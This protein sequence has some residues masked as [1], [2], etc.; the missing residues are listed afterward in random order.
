MEVRSESSFAEDWLYLKLNKQ[1]KKSKRKA[2][3][4]NSPECVSSPSW[5]HFAGM[6]QREDAGGVC[7]LVAGGQDYC[8]LSFYI[9]GTLFRDGIISRELLCCWAVKPVNS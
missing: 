3:L 4:I 1:T 5:P 8:V 7:G 9:L 6:S 2:K